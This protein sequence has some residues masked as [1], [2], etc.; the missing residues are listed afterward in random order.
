MHSGRTLAVSVYSIGFFSLS[1]EPIFGLLIPLWVLH[2]GASNF[3]V[4]I[5]VGGSSL[6]PAIFSI[7]MGGLADRVNVKSLLLYAGVGTALC[8]ALY[9]FLIDPW[10]LFC[11]HMVVGSLSTFLWIGAQAYVA[12]LGADQQRPRLMGNFSSATTLGTFAGPLLVGYLLD[13]WGFTWTFFACSLWAL[14]VPLLAF[15]LPPTDGEA[16]LNWSQ[17][18][19]SFT[20]FKKAMFLC[21]IPAILFVLMATFLRLSTYAIRNSYYPVYLKGL[22]FSG[23]RIG[24]LSSI[25]SLASSFSALGTGRLS[26]HIQP[27][28]LLLLALGLAVVPLALTPA[29]SSFIHLL[30][31]SALWGTGIGIT[32][33]LL[34]SILANAT[35]P[36]LRG[37][38]IGLRTATNRFA[39]SIVP[40]FLGALIQKLGLSTGFY[41]IGIAQ[42]LMIVALFFYARIV[43][44]RA[45]VEK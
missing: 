2:L 40:I 9:P 3:L 38:S 24:L 6:L 35:R 29:F 12:K 10:L 5:I 8:T 33:P 44:P 31:L 17:L 19:P 7:P 34:L 27:S 45:P 18:K 11:L 13:S 15:F 32:L 20:D 21:T 37:L 39:L 41:V 22:G 28:H 16:F 14:M 42:V 25:N 23:T 43:F 1:L 30:T 36:E 4:G 26:R